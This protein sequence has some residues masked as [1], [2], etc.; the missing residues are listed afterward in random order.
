MKLNVKWFS[1]TAL[2]VVT[3]PSAVL[4][5]W[6]SINGFG[7]EMVRLFES[8]HPGGGLS[9]LN[10]IENGFTGCI[11]GILIN[12]FYAAVDSFIAGFAF[13]SLYNLFLSRF[14]K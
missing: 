6:T 4:F 7:L 10:N 14:E 9:I 1:I 5:V 12:V 2:I 13:S 11:P 3:V 8:L